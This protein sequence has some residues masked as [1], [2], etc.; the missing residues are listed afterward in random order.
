MTPPKE[1]SSS[2]SFLRND[3]GGRQSVCLAPWSEPWLYSFSF[4]YTRIIFPQVHDP[5]TG[6]KSK[7]S[8]LKRP[9]K[10]KKKK[11]LYLSTVTFDFPSGISRCGDVV[12]MV[13]RWREGK[14]RKTQKFAS[15]QVPISHPFL[16][17][18]TYVIF[19]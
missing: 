5:V 3:A 8:H 10:R 11:L 1:A 17:L 14:T 19:R 15:V 4:S 9:S 16:S 7:P 2:S 12:V 18:F 6:C 13:G